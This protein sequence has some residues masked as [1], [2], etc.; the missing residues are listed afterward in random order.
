M[1]AAGARAGIAC[2][3]IAALCGCG[4]AVQ[5]E[6][7]GNERAP[8][9]KADVS[10]D[11]DRDGREIDLE[12]HDLPPPQ[13]FGEQYTRYGVWLRPENGA[14]SLFGFLEYQSD[15]EFGGMEET[16]PLQS[17]EIIISAETSDPGPEPSDAVVMRRAVPPP[18]R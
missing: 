3:L 17:F 10:I 6:A 13:T 15:L 12:V 2:T 9:A 16:T 7:R 14:P 8:A 18:T 4:G 5:L 1:S 11:E